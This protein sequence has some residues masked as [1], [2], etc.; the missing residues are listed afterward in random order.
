MEIILLA[1]MAAANIACFIIG[2]KVG[3]KVVK[4]ED[5]KLP[6]I[7]PME[8]YRDREAKREARE[9]QDKLETIMR[10]IETYDG[11]PRGQRDVRR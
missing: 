10:N 7:N 6:T 2:A 1:V 3:Q 8:A 11:T 9:E 5:I 4:G